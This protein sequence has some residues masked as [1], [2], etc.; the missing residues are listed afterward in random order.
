MLRFK[1]VERRILQ[2]LNNRVNQINTSHNQVELLD[3]VVALHREKLSQ[4]VT[5]LGYGRSDADT[6]IRYEEDLFRAQLALV[7]V[8]FNYKAGL[9]EL[10]LTKNTLLDKYW[11]EPL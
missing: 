5:R 1:R 9:I 10:E 7:T 11:N 3:Q 2:E 8:Q 4:Q 6:L